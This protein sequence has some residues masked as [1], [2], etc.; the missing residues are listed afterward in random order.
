M[1]AADVFGD[2]GVVFVFE[3]SPQSVAGMLFVIDNEN[4]GLHFQRV[5]SLTSTILTQFRDLSN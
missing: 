5:K 4:R 1:R 3:Q 2:V